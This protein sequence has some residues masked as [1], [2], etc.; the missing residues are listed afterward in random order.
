MKRDI[1]IGGAWPYAN[2][3]LHVGH[4]AA[5]LPGDIIATYYRL[6]GDNVIYVSGTD[7]HGTPITQ[8]AIKEN[9]TPNEIAEF[10]HNEF[11]KTFN[12]A[13]FKYDKYTKTTTKEHKEFVQNFFIKLKDNN[14]LYEKEE[15]EE[16]CLT[17]D[18]FLADR[19]ITGIC[20][21]CGLE[22]S[23]DQCDNCLATFD[24]SEVKDKRCKTCNNKV[25]E[26]LNKH[27][28]FKLSSFQNE[29]QDLINK[30][31]TNWRKN[32]IGESQ[33]YLDMGLIDRAVTRE[34]TW[35]IDVPI[36]GYE[37]K[38]IYVW[39]E[40]V[41]GYLSAGYLSAEEKNI[42]FYKFISK[43][44]KN[45]KTYYVHGKDNIPFHTIIFPAL[46][47]A[48]KDDYKDPDY[49]LSSAYINLNNEKMSKSTGNLITVN[50]LLDEFSQDTVR[51]YF[52][53][54]GP[55]TKDSNCSREEI[56]INHNKFLVGVLGNFVNR[57][58][59][60]INKKF[61]GKITKGNIDKEIRKLTLD[62]YDKV[63][64]L[65]EKGELKAAITLILDYIS[66][67]NKYYDQNEPWIKV[68]ENIKEFNDITYTCVYMIANIS[69]LINPFMKESSQKIKDMLNIKEHSFK[70]ILIDEDINVNEVPLLF[71]RID[72]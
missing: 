65:I 44:N 5:L 68:K 1:F 34:L 12:K 30:N 4:L 47:H 70:E 67:G 3:Y 17:C 50:E 18:K 23:G 39:F 58:L 27:L 13:G 14:Y 53:Y 6:N 2:N 25:S 28:Y 11:V 59:S 24:S 36:K 31:K 9:R 41:L 55:E 22:S 21:N 7:S 49:I 40:A 72:E 48:S 57:N 45:L 19:D 32:A 42:D 35:G 15:P 37:D 16:Y 54:N 38:K 56:I 26:K 62:T 29:L 33:K 66:H 46:L 69:N 43:E 8:R 71:E 60:Y 52:T 51:F 20:P 61:D 10:Y 63:S 64:T